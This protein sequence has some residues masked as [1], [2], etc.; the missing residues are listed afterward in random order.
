MYRLYYAYAILWLGIFS[1]KK[2][3]PHMQEQAHIDNLEKRLK[4]LENTVSDWQ[5]WKNITRDSSHKI[6]I[7]EGLTLG[8]QRD[9]TDLKVGSSYVARK[10]DSIE[11]RLDNHD[12]RFDALDKKLDLIIKLLSPGE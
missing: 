12:E 6:G 7:A 9:I 10:V 5:D 1:S 2:E 3:V 4:A 8:F 11:E